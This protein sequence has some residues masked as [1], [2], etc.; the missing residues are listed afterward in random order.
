[1]PP[2]PPR[3]RPPSS[4]ASVVL[5]THNQSPYLCHLI[6]SRTHLVMHLLLTIYT[7]SSSNSNNN[8]STSTSTSRALVAAVVVAAGAALG[9]GGA[10][11][12]VSSRSV[13]KPPSPRWHTVP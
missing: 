7:N 13:C 2:W 9:G 8:S 10:A 12:V 6:P 1:M 11:L 4:E 5:S 3:T